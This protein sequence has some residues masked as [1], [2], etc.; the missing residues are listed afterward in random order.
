M[1]VKWILFCQAVASSFDVPYW[2]FD[3][4]RPMFGEPAASESLKV[5]KSKVAETERPQR[6]LLCSMTFRPSD[7]AGSSSSFPRG[8]PAA[9]KGDVCFAVHGP[10]KA[11]SSLS[12]IASPF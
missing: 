7:A 4:E 10:E 1:G 9:A 2:K 5:L 8:D 3:V 6:L 12:R 11:A